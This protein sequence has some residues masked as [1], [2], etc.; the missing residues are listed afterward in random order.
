MVGLRIFVGCANRGMFWNR[1]D[2]IVGLGI[3]GKISAF[4]TQLRS[5]SVYRRG[6]MPTG[7]AVLLCDGR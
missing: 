1:F 3:W 5:L 6:R 4:G 2:V 7:G